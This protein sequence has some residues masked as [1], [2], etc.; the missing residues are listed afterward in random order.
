M[1]K[2]FRQRMS[3]SGGSRHS[4]ID[5]ATTERSR[6]NS[7][8]L[9]DGLD[10][11]EGDSDDPFDSSLDRRTRSHW[12]SSSEERSK[13]RRLHSASSAVTVDRMDP[14]T[15]SNT[16]ASG[17]PLG[18]KQRAKNFLFRR[19]SFSSLD[20]HKIDGRPARIDPK[21]VSNYA[22]R[23]HSDD[24]MLDA[25]DREPDSRTGQSGSATGGEGGLG[26]DSSASAGKKKSKFSRS[27]N[28]FTSM[29]HR[30]RSRDATHR[31]PESGRVSTSGGSSDGG[32]TDASGPVDSGSAIGSEGPGQSATL[33]RRGHRNS[34]QYM[35]PPP[36]QQR[37]QR[38]PQRPYQPPYPPYQQRQ[39]SSASALATNLDE[40]SGFCLERH[41]LRSRVGE[42]LASW[43]VVPLEAVSPWLVGGSGRGGG[44][45][46]KRLS[47]AFKKGSIFAS[48]SPSSSS[49]PSTPSGSLSSAVF[50]GGTG[51]S[52]LSSVSQFSGS[53]AEQLNLLCQ[54]FNQAV[55]LRK[56]YRGKDHLAARLPRRS[57]GHWSSSSGSSSRTTAESRSFTKQ[58]SNSTTASKDS[59]LELNNNKF[60]FDEQGGNSR[61]QSPSQA[62]SSPNEAF[63][64]QHQ[65]QQQQ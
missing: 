28:L 50:S 34:E 25:G 31:K 32:W 30:S 6:V 3:Q 44:G 27:L 61:R 5:D 4:V 58:A 46:S 40:I 53:T 11:L 2:S 65:Y 48:A 16:A 41:Q 23:H 36:T 64:H 18:L 62:S 42:V 39:V 17:Q 56:S 19:R 29:R 47:M 60:R 45:K 10:S 14:A 26:L 22:K 13:V 8:E 1:F 12:R 55:T 20:T 59:A 38:Q 35:A 15:A 21:L 9:G 7:V 49:G 52:N 57:S 54:Q 63:S 37:Q 24:C 33:G 43:P 51:G